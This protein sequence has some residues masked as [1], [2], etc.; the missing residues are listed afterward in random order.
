MVVGCGST[1]RPYAPEKKVVKKVVSDDFGYFEYK[2][3]TTFK[4][5]FLSLEPLWGNDASNSFRGKNEPVLVFDY[6]GSGSMLNIRLRD[7]LAGSAI[8]L[9]SVRGKDLNTNGTFIPESGSMGFLSVKEEGKLSY[10]S[11]VN[12][13][14]DKFKA[15]RFQSYLNQQIDT[16]ELD[17]VDNTTFKG[18]LEF[19][20]RSKIDGHGDYEKVVNAE[21]ECKIPEND[22]L[23]LR[24]RFEKEYKRNGSF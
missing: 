20:R 16:L 17:K 24:E 5:K 19:T 14:P 22:W 4:C 8:S 10:L 9:W 1:P 12:F 21:I 23:K 13:Q 2:D 11:T 18:K 3:E 6:F 7:R 15:H